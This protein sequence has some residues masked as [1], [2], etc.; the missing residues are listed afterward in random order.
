MPYS[1]ILFFVRFSDYGRRPGIHWQILYII[2]LRSDS[3]H[4]FLFR[5]GGNLSHCHSTLYSTTHLTPVLRRDNTS[6]QRWTTAIGDPA[7]HRSASE[8][9]SCRI[10]Y[11]TT[12][13]TAR[14][15]RRDRRRI[16][17][18]GSSTSCHRWSRRRRRR[19]HCRRAGSRSISIITPSCFSG[20]TNSSASTTW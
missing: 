3:T 13:P 12:L 9:Q 15:I 2:G 5:F 14:I 1:P 10:V 8:H 6:W 17:A 16:G 7:H 18:T 20:T 4:S 19:R 11:F